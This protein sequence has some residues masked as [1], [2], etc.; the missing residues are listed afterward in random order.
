MIDQVRH[1]GAYGLDWMVITDHGSQMH[2]KIGVERR[3]TRTS[4]QPARGSLAPWSS[5]DWSG[6]SRPPGMAPSS[7]IRA[8]TRSRCSRR[9]KPATAARRRAPR[10]AR[11]PTRRWPSPG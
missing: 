2:A 8:A 9:S 11:R 6:T 7:C 1:A 4:W 5:R 3:S 10:Q